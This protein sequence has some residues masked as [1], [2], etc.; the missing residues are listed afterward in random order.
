MDGGT[1]RLLDASGRT[2]WAPTS[3]QIG[4]QAAQ[5]HRQMMGG[6]RSAPSIAFPLG[7]MAR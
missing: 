3:T 1:L 7:W 5:M 6:G 2:V 4:Q